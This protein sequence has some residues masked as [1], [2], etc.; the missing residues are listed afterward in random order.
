MLQ[1]EYKLRDV[2]TRMT[3]SAIP[4]CRYARRENKMFSYH[5]YESWEPLGYSVARPIEAIGKVLNKGEQL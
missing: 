4:Y 3:I 5:L 1:R 2:N